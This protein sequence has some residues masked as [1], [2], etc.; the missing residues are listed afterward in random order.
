MKKFGHR[1]FNP[2]SLEAELTLGYCLDRPSRAE[3]QK[4]QM[5][6]A[7]TPAMGFVNVCCLAEL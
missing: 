7:G 4:K 2:A 5:A 3:N 1:S 6:L